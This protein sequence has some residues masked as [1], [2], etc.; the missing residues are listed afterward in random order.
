MLARES[1]WTEPNQV[2]YCSSSVNFHC[3]VLVSDAKSTTKVQNPSYLS[4]YLS[5]QALHAGILLAN[6]VLV[7][8]SGLMSPSLHNYKNCI[9]TMAFYI[10]SSQPNLLACALYIFA[11][12]WF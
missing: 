9:T 1:S 5:K 8:Q 4:V 6:E 12:P 2:Y 11:G 10:P 7:I 3:G